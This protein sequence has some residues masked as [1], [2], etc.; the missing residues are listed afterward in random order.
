[1]TAVLESAFGASNVTA[2]VVNSA[3]DR[4][5]KNILTFSASIAPLHS[6]YTAE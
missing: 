5:T 2:T 3:K 4:V 6:K 1:M